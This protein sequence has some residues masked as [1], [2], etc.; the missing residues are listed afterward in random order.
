MV[1]LD[2]PPYEYRNPYWWGLR[3]SLDGVGEVDLICP[4]PQHQFSRE[5][6]ESGSIHRLNIYLDTEAPYDERERMEFVSKCYVYLSKQQSRHPYRRIL[7]ARAGGVEGMLSAILSVL[8]PVWIEVPPGDDS[9]RGRLSN[10]LLSTA[11]RCYRLKEFGWPGPSEA[12]WPPDPEVF[13]SLFR[14][15]GAASS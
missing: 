11:Q 4:S 2:V 3:Q 5:S 12:S 9:E 6:V 1:T 10:S 13:E 7:V 14:E 8:S 15:A